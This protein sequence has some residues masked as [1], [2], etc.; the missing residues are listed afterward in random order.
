MFKH[1]EWFYMAQ[2]V[3]GKEVL[4]RRIEAYGYKLVTAKKQNGY[5]KY[6]LKN[7]NGSIVCGK[8]NP[9]NLTEI[10]K[11]LDKKMAKNNDYPH[12]LPEQADWPIEYEV[13]VMVSAAYKFGKSQGYSSTGVMT[14]I[15]S[16]IMGAYSIQKHVPLY[17]PI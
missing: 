14:V 7:S 16:Q 4:E 3:S 11:W 6:R 1:K 13:F 5:Y 12:T 17:I 10:A 15:T 8:R 9:V 2:R